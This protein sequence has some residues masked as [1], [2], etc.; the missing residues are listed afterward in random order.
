MK[1]ADHLLKMR[2]FEYNASISSFG[3]ISY[4]PLGRMGFQ[5]TRKGSMDENMTI[6]LHK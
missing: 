6:Y 3:D 4:I 5:W 2:K 1:E